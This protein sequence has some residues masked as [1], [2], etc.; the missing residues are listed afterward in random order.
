MTQTQSQPVTPTAPTVPLPDRV[1]PESRPGRGGRSMSPASASGAAHPPL[2][3]QGCPFLAL[4]TPPDEGER[5]A[6]AMENWLQACS[7]DEPFALELVGTRRE[8]GFLLRASSEQQFTM[9]CKQLEAQ[10]PQ[11]EIQ[12]V[13]PSAD[14]LLL[15]KHEHA[16]VGEFSLAQPSY[17]PLKTFSGK[18]LAEPGT[19]PLA[20]ILASME[21][22]G[23]GCRI[24]IQLALVRAPETWLSADIRKSVEHAL[25]PER[26]ALAASL[27]NAST[28]SDA[29]QGAPLVALLGAAIGGIFAFRW[30]REQAWLPLT[31]LGVALAIGLVAYIWW[32]LFQ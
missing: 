28:K 2:E 17:L 32:K 9:L 1:A 31:L 14:P 15:H 22:I 5:Q 7:S 12:R 23:P 20:G 3:P 21:A 25:Q 8:Q 11:A 6:Q 4:I 27:K 24:I 18:A 29:A 30:Y 13:K 10:Y 26:D 19:D 16:V